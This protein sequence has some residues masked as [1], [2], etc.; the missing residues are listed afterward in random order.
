MAA[1]NPTCEVWICNFHNAEN[2]VESLWRALCSGI[3]TLAVSR[4][5]N[6]GDCVEACSRDLASRQAISGRTGWSQSALAL[7]LRQAHVISVRRDMRRNQN[8]GQT[9][10]GPGQVLGVAA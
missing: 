8:D 7:Q 5:G 10:R 9:R 1:S 6:K 3:L 2:I 4:R